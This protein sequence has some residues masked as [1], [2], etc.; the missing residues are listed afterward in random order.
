MSSAFADNA[1]VKDEGREHHGLSAIRDWTTEK[2]DYQVE[3]LESSRMGDKAVVL[4]AIRGNFA[5]SPITVHYAFVFE[6]QKIARLE[7]R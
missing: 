6:G 3:P 4:V 1:V 7:I 5:G 2:Y